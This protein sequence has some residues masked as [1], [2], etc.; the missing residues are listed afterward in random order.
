ML[1]LVR[2]FDWHAEVVGLFLRKLGQFHA[3]AFEVQGSTRAP[4][5]AIDAL[6]NGSVR[7]SLV[8]MLWQAIHACDF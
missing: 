8:E 5:V 1:R 6:V 2:P 7:D 4:R 3:D